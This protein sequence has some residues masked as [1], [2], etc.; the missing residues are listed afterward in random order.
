MDY[1]L[2][3]ALVPSGWAGSVGVNSLPLSA[4]CCI[5]FGWEHFCAFFM[6]EPS[7]IFFTL[8]VDCFG[9]GFL[10][11]H[12]SIFWFHLGTVGMAMQEITDPFQMAH[13][14]V[15][16]VIECHMAM[17]CMLF[18]NPFAP[19]CCCCFI[20][21]FLVDGS[22]CSSTFVDCTKCIIAI[23]HKTYADRARCTRWGGHGGFDWVRS[24]ERTGLIWPGESQWVRSTLTEKDEF[25]VC[26]LSFE[27]WWMEGWQNSKSKSQVIRNQSTLFHLWCGLFASSVQIA[28]RHQWWWNRIER[29]GVSQPIMQ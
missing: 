7:W 23:K 5:S 1:S 17:F 21:C 28:R 20:S 16:G 25:I 29:V 27:M 26:E 9:V 8:G 22:L 14:S 3:L 12:L 19:F 24:V 15:F 11:R 4:N 2:L 6:V 10:M 18:S 13:W